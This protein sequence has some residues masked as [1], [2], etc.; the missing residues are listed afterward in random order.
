VMGLLASYP[1]SVALVTTAILVS[2][3]YAFVVDRN[4]ASQVMATTP[5]GPYNPLAEIRLIQRNGQQLFGTLRRAVSE[6]GDGLRLLAALRNDLSFPMGRQSVS[7]KALARL[8]VSGHSWFG[9][10]GR[11]NARDVATNMIT[12]SHAE[13]DVFDQA[14]ASGIRGEKGVLHV[15]RDLCTFCDRIDGVRALAKQLGLRELFITT[16]SGSQ[17]LIID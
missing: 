14:I 6:G 13:G 15:D 3:L 10:S 9:M 1:T 7:N 2:N 11:D 5:S 16:P 17:N 12:L 4:Y 8:E